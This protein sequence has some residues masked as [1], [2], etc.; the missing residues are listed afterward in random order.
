[1]NVPKFKNERAEREYK[2]MPKRL[3]E[4]AEYF[5]AIC[6]FYYVTAVVT[7]VREGV[8]GDS[9]VHEAGRGIDYRDETTL[10]DGEKVR[11][12]TGEQ[13][14]QICELINARF[15]REDGKVTILHH[16]FQGGP[17]HFHIQI[18]VSWLEPGEPK[19]A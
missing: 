7:R 3:R 5:E 18:P 4:V 10:P 9:G 14:A 8:C 15:A 17:G 13:V 2:L 6:G 16:S 19:A 11:L 1:M 12:F